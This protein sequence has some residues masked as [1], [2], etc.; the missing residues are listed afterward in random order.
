[1]AEHR[2][3]VNSIT[4][5]VLF[6]K[7]WK[8]FQEIENSDES[9]VNKSYQD[10]VKQC[11]RNLESCTRMVSILGI[12]S[13]NEEIDEVSTLN[14]KFF[15]LPAF[16]GDLTLK[17]SDIERKS[18]VK[19]ADVYFKDFLKR[20]FCYKV[21]KKDLSKYF[22]N[23]HENNKESKKLPP[24]SLTRDEKVAAYKENKNL[25][26]KIETMLKRM[27]DVPETLDD[28][29]MREYHLDWLLLWVN[30]CIENINFADRELEMLEMMEVRGGK[31]F[32][33]SHSDLPP[34]KP[35]LIT[36]EMIQKQVFGAGY[37]NLPTMTEDEY[38]EKEVRE[39]KI[40]MDYDPNA[41][42]NEKKESEDEDEK[43]H[44]EE[45]LRKA[46]EW[47]EYKDTHRRGDG[48]KERH[49]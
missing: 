26:S 1:M 43:E 47:D 7:S 45:E 8:Q 25:T 32:E 10:N 39:G 11:I 48:N 23:R 44:D 19:N 14:L 18:C 34:M 41:H 27:T 2:E 29:T 49:G 46:R 38:F 36:K 13:S 4:L 16:L 30:K 6:D 17:S 33:P 40:V 9:S 12:F 21:T 15:L 3:D 31:P 20:C 42:A 28:E 24:L 35:I 5:S 37:K 22:G